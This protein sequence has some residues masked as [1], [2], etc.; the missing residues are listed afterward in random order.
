MPE[1]SSVDIGYLTSSVESPNGKW[2]KNT[3]SKNAQSK[4]GK[5]GESATPKGFPAG[6]RRPAQL[7]VGGAA[8]QATAYNIDPGTSKN[9]KRIG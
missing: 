1:L 7:S 4:S 3:K 9:K 6:K 5:V 8:P 2:K